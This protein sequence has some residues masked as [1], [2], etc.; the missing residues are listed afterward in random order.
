[1]RRHIAKVGTIALSVALAIGSLIATLAAAPAAQ[2]APSILVGAC[3]EF[4]VCWGGD[5]PTPWS[6]N[7]SQA[8]LTTLGLGS[9]TPFIV[10]QDACCTIR[11]GVTTITFDTPGGPV[12]E[13]ADEF[14]GFSNH[15][16]PCNLCEV[17]TVASFFIPA[18]A[19]AAVI[20]G[21]FGNSIVPDTAG[22]NLYLGGLPAV[23]EP[24]TWTMMLVGFGAMG[25]AMRRSRS[26]GAAFA[27]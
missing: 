27:A 5:T 3:V 20:S 16:D 4:D 9:D 13:T 23:P 21:A 17:D 1:V 14:N 7:L 6:H 25:A 18:D 19:T 8:D 22:L 10:A 24:A 15:N 26:R 2:A 12:T 11:L